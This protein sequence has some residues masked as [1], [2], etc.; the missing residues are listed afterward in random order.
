MLAGSGL[1]GARNFSTWHSGY[2]R[3]T[4]DG[5]I[6]TVEICVRIVE[7]IIFPICVVLS[8]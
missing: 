5:K 4:Y 2:L 3:L 7:G 6:A 8:S 1:L